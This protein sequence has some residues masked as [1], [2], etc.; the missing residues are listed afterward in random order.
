M[1]SKCE[2]KFYLADVFGRILYKTVLASAVY[3][4]GCSAA[5]SAAQHCMAITFTGAD[6]PSCN[7]YITEVDQTGKLCNVFILQ[8]SLLRTKIMISVKEPKRLT[9]EEWLSIYVNFRIWV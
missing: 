8:C 3:C 5:C 7:K 1:K 4:R 2:I 6:P 9:K